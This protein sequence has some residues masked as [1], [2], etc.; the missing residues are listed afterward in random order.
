V[1]KAGIELAVD[2][3]EVIGA[4]AS[5]QIRKPQQRL[6]L[7]LMGNRKVAGDFTCGKQRLKE[8]I[9]L[10]IELGETSDKVGPRLKN[11]R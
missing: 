11:D 5:H 9:V 2:T 4:C 10:V 1:G 3:A 8:P 6:S 7:R